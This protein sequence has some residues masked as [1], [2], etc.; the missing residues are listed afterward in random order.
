MLRADRALARD[1]A[2]PLAALCVL[3]TA[4]D[5][6]ANVRT[7]VLRE[8]DDQL[9]VFFSATSPK[10]A[11]IARGAPPQVLIYLPTQRLQYRLWTRPRMVS[12]ALMETYWPLRPSA[13]KNL[14][15][16]YNLTS[17]QGAAITDRTTLRAAIAA[18]AADPRASQTVPPAGASGCFLDPHRIERLLLDDADPPHDRRLYELVGDAWRETVLVP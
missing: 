15:W 14:D 2:D 10:A 8:I 18:A 3:A 6:V 9:A 7:L 4:A 5:D 16:F 13:A 12:R 17:A 11:Q 1:Q